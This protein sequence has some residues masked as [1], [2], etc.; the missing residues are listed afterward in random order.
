MFFSK[1][2][3][4]NFSGGTVDK[5]LPANAQDIGWI[6]GPGRFHMPWGS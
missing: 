4:L 6:P 3:E 1:P 5:N 2:V